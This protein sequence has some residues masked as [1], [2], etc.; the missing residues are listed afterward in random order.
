MER[1]EPLSPEQLEK[2]V[3]EA[4]KKAFS[5][6][7]AENLDKHFYTFG[8]FTDDSMQFLYPVANTE[9]GLSI[10]VDYY[11]ANVD[12]KRTSGR[13]TT[14][15]DLRWAYGDWEFFHSLRL[16]EFTE[17]NNGLKAYFHSDVDLKVFEAVVTMQRVS[18]TGGNYPKLPKI[19]GANL[20]KTGPIWHSSRRF[21]PNSQPGC[22]CPKASVSS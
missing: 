14:R 5:A 20:P 8:L 12:P 16:D 4:S 6:I 3:Y 7:I 18:G 13:V 21:A 15:N 9:E 22:H 10:I 19:S 11:R 1:V 2:M 17:I